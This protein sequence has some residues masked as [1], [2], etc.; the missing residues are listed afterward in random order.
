MAVM[1]MLCFEINGLSELQKF[2]SCRVMNEVGWLLGYWDD[3]NN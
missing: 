3:H 1:K 2:V